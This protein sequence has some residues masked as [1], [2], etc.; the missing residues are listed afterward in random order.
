[1]GGV[2]GEDGVVDQDAVD[3]VV[4]VGGH[5]GFFKEVFVDAAEVEGESAE[6]GLVRMLGIGGELT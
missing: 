5:D 1:V 6:R 3:A 4:V 2:A